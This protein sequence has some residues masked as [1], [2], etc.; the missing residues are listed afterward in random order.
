MIPESYWDIFS[1]TRQHAKDTEACQAC[2]RCSGSHAHSEWVPSLF[3]SFKAS[4]PEGL[5][6]M[7][8]HKQRM[9]GI[10]TYL[11]HIKFTIWTML[12][13]YLCTRQIHWIFQSPLPRVSRQ[14]LWKGLAYVLRFSRSRFRMQPILKLRL[15]GKKHLSRPTIQGPATPFHSFWWC[16]SLMAAQHDVNLLPFQSQPPAEFQWNSS[17]PIMHYCARRLISCPVAIQLVGA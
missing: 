15:T 2:E 7:Q 3:W 13:V 4:Y 9:Y 8:G 1:V 10:C 17:H 16:A 5:E 11:C 6:T 12:H 14:Q